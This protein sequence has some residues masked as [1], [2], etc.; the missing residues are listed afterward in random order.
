MRRTRP[1]LL[2]MIAISALTRDDGLDL[3]RM[4]PGLVTSRL[5]VGHNADSCRSRCGPS[6]LTRAWQS[7]FR[8]SQRYD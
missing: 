5:R 6:P 8:R 3:A 1:V 7:W 4:P 2:R